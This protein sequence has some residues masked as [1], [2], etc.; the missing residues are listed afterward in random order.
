[1]AKAIDQK[2]KFPNRP[3]PQCGK[4]IHIKSKKHPECGWGMAQ[5]ASTAPVAAKRGRPAKKK[6]VAW[7]TAGGVT[8]DDIAVVKALVRRMGADRVQQLA[9]VLAK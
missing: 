3:C 1:V 6:P 2:P 4:P 7:A 5:Q 8:L 9:A